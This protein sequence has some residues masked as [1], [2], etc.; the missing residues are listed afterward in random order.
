MQNFQDS[1]MQEWA[2]R[3]GLQSPL[4]KCPTLKERFVT[5]D[6]QEKQNFP[7]QSPMCGTE[8]EDQERETKMPSNSGGK[9]CDISSTG[10]EDVRSADDGVYRTWLR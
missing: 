10:M 5:L 3:L 7:L 6:H 2:G 9:I 1:K 8:Q 4:K